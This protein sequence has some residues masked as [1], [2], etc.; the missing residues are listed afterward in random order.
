[1]VAPLPYGAHDLLYLRTCWRCM[2]SAWPDVISASHKSERNRVYAHLM[3]PHKASGHRA[4]LRLTEA[5]L[6][7]SMLQRLGA[8]AQG[9]G[10]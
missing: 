5:E 1:M 7:N 9:P 8:V 10:E 6:I 2:G 3:L 4:L